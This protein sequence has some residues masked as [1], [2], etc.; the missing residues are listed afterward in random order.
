MNLPLS[1]VAARVRS[2]SSSPD[3]KPPR[4]NSPPSAAAAAAADR[5][6]HHQHHLHLHGPNDP[7][8]RRE[9]RRKGNPNVGRIRWEPPNRVVGKMHPV[10]VIKDKE[11]AAYWFQEMGGGGSGERRAEICALPVGPVAVI[12]PEALTMIHLMA[13]EDKTLGGENVGRVTLNVLAIEDET[14]RIDPRRAIALGTLLPQVGSTTRLNVTLPA[15][16]TYMLQ[17]KCASEKKEAAER[18][19][20]EQA[21]GTSMA[22]PTKVLLMLE[23]VEIDPGALQ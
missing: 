5:S 16:G 22:I 21:K 7:A 8:S 11:K 14:T 4:P 12:E 17:V 2:A 15:G 1:E 3:K 23:T 20:L 10:E 19:R 6:H 18:Q 9:R 13:W